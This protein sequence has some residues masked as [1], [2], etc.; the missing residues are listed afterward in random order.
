MLSISDAAKLE[1]NKISNNSVWIILIDVDF[2]NYGI[3]DEIKLC[4][5][6]EE[7]EWPTGSGQIW[8]P[9]PFEL[10]VKDDTSKGEI[11]TI[12]LKISNVNRVMQHYLEEVRGGVESTVTLR[13]V[14]S[15][16]LDIE[17]PEIEEEFEILSTYSD[18][19]WVYFTLGA[20]NPF[21]L[22]FPRPKYIQNFC[23]WQFKDEYCRYSGSQYTTCNKTFT[24]CKKRGNS[25]RF[26]GFSGVSAGLWS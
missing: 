15:E 12:E 6:N 5:N 24:D 4:Y 16:H 14:N 21:N 25:E 22:Q 3:T 17:T 23:R 7:I 13:L 9:F 1:K 20:P 2:S 8:Q 26:G 18:A 10:G 11:A 19:N